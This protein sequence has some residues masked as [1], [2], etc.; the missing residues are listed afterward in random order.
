MRLA[1]SLHGAAARYAREIPRD[2]GNHAP[3][4]GA[5]A[6][7][8][9]SHF[10]TRVPSTIGAAAA[11]HEQDEQGLRSWR[12]FVAPDGGFEAS[13]QRSQLGVAVCR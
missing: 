12:Q 7:S 2:I 8:M 5:S 6:Y 1:S 4:V 10:G 3:Q 9:E 13:P 11:G